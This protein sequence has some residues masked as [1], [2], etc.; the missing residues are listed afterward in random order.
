MSLATL[1]TLAQD[2]GFRAKV[3]MAMCSAALDVVGEAPDAD[4]I[5]DEKRHRL[6]MAV[7][8]D[9]GAAMLDAFAYAA[10]SVGTLN[11]QSADGDIQFIVNSIWS[12]MAGVSGS[13]L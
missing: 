1:S 4:N 2:S 6:G 8:V 12:D 3:R 5:K 13:E 11:D 7:L 9:G 10:A